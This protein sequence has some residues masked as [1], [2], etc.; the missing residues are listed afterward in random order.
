M[1]WIMPYLTSHRN[2]A[3]TAIAPWGFFGWY[4]QSHSTPKPKPLPGL[5]ARSKAQSRA[6]CWSSAWENFP[7]IV[8]FLWHFQVASL[9][10]T[11]ENTAPGMIRWQTCSLRSFI[12]KTFDSSKDASS[13]AQRGLSQRKEVQGKGQKAEPT[14]LVSL[15][16]FSRKIPHDILHCKF[17]DGKETNSHVISHVV[18]AYKHQNNWTSGFTLVYH[19]LRHL[20]DAEEPLRPPS[21]GVLHSSE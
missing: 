17:E 7:D 19:C 18:P 2:H 9:Y 10:I 20:G 8:Q 21:L 5:A 15:P 3:R 13:S 12:I 16:K 11:K 4:Q 14:N 1:L 6:L